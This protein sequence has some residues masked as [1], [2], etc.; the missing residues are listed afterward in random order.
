MGDKIREKRGRSHHPFYQYLTYGD[1]LLLPQMWVCGSR[2]PGSRMVT[3]LHMEDR[4]AQCRVCCLVPLGLQEFQDF[5]QLCCNMMLPG[6]D[7]F[8]PG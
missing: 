8:A 4:S 2:F 1:F 3:A 5:Q 6:K 7:G